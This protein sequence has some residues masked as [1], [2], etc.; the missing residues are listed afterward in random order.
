MEIKQSTQQPWVQSSHMQGKIMNL[1]Q[2]PILSGGVY[3]FSRL[4]WT[5]ATKSL[6]YC[7]IRKL[8]SATAL[9]TRRMRSCVW[10]SQTWVT[11]CC[12]LY[13]M[14][15]SLSM[16]VSNVDASCSKEYWSLEVLDF[17]VVTV[18]RRLGTGEGSWDNLLLLPSTPGRGRGRVCRTGNGVTGW[19]SRRLVD[20]KGGGN[21]SE[22]GWVALA[23]RDPGSRW[24]GIDVLVDVTVAVGAMV[25]VDEIVGCSWFVGLGVQCSRN[26]K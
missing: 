2:C 21:D 14:S 20:E 17:L 25:C 22:R 1:M 7:R 11:L 6:V 15:S 3:F 10:A 19:T 4:S 13:S 5:V 16:M 18:R 26:L 8:S 24:R 23:T 9:F 12:S